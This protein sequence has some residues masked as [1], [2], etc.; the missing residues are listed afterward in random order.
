MADSKPQDLFEK[1]K[2]IKIEGSEYVEAIAKSF[3]LIYMGEEYGGLGADKEFEN[4]WEFIYYLHDNKP[5]QGHHY[6]KIG[7][8]VYHIFC[9]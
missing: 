1:Y 8:Q 9:P 6:F 4:E 3:G 2:E 5:E 7:N